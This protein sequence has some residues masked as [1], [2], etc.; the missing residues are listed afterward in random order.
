MCAALFTKFSYPVLGQICYRCAVHMSSAAVGGQ[1]DPQH[2]RQCHD[3]GET[4][5]Q[6]PG[7]GHSH[8]VVAVALIQGLVPPT[9]FGH[10]SE[11]RGRSVPSERLRVQTELCTVQEGNPNRKWRTD[12]RKQS[13]VTSWHNESSHDELVRLDFVIPA[14]RH[15]ILAHILIAAF[16]ESYKVVLFTRTFCCRL[17]KQHLLNVLKVI[18]YILTERKYNAKSEL[19]ITLLVRCSCKMFTYTQN[20]LVVVYAA[21]YWH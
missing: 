3:R 9:G 1:I 8:R 6:C 17:A 21:V 18:L 7:P 2:H 12:S 19:A 5:Q 20:L 4:L 15:I 16:T 11:T 10:D 14:F 13:S